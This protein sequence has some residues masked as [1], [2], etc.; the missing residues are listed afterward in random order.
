MCADAGYRRLVLG[1]AA[2]IDADAALARFSTAIHPGDQ[3]L[4]HS[5]NR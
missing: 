5:L 2:D 3:M 4:L 1:F